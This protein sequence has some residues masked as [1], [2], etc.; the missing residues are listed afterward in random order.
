M[1]LHVLGHVQVDQRIGIAEHELREGLRQKRLPH[2]GRPHE[3]E[4]AHRS[5][6]VFQAA[7][8]LADRFCD[9]PDRFLLA[10]DGLVQLLLQLQ[11]ALG[12]LLLQTRQRHARHLGD[13][14]G[15]DVLVDNAVDLLGPLPPFLLDT[16]LLTP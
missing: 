1:L 8:G 7:A 16:V 10:H 11:Q 15:N 14:L 13:H 12:L 3:D 2:A 4:R 6:W 9:R 5:P